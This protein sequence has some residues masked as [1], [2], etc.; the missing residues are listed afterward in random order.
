MRKLLVVPLLGCLVFLAGFSTYN[1]DHSEIAASFF[2]TYEP[3]N[4]AACVA[5]NPEP[6]KPGHVIFLRDDGARAGDNAHPCLNWGTDMCAVH[7][8]CGGGPAQAVAPIDPRDVERLYLQ[9]AEFALQFMTKYPERTILNV[10]S[11][12]LQVTGCTP[13]VVIG[14]LVLKPTVFAD[15]LGGTQLAVAE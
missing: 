5:C 14:N 2:T 15:L 11:S 7:D 10:S 6:E 8:E 13:D 9:P 4:C 1:T 3:T 12:A